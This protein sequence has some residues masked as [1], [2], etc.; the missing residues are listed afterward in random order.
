[1]SDIQS[2]EELERQG[3]VIFENYP[4][5]DSG[6]MPLSE[7]VDIHR[8]AEMICETTAARGVDLWAVE[9]LGLS[10]S[11]WAKA[12]DRSRSTVSR[13]VRRARDEDY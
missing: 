9:E 8:L 3:A 2:D 10:P 12:T 11:A 7:D 4:E 1:M 6:T 5:N 13:N